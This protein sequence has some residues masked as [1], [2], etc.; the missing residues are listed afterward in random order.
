M[1]TD[2]PELLLK[3][4]LRPLMGLLFEVSDEDPKAA[5]ENALEAISVF[6]PHTPVELRLAVRVCIFNILG[7][8]ACAQAGMQDLPV[9]RSIRLHQG[10]ITLVREADKAEARLE[11]L[12]TMRAEGQKQPEPEEVEELTA[13]ESPKVEKAMDLLDETKAIAG[14]A[15]ILGVTWPQ[16][17]KQRKLEKQLAK[18]RDREARMQAQSKGLPPTT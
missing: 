3:T 2:I 17:Y 1:L 14:Q 13:T 16:A 8:Q 12:Q 9:D 6:N 18:R 7:N 15:A 5:F 4:L 11:K 10:A